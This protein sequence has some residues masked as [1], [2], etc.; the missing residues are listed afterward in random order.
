MGTR[1]SQPRLLR[2]LGQQ[3]DKQGIDIFDLRAADGDY[4]LECAD[5]NPPFTDLLHLRYSTV[6][7]EALDVAAAQLR[8]PGFTQ[9]NFQGMAEL[10][11]A[12]GRYVERHNATLLRFSAPG[13]VI[14]G[15]LLRIEYQTRDVRHHSEDLTTNQLMDTA[16]RMYKQRAHIRGDSKDRHFAS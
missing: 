11:R 16:I 9:V 6:E 10:L 8:R 4:F 5:P 7:L 15:S 2:T 1:N 14:D 3:L 13:T 12:T